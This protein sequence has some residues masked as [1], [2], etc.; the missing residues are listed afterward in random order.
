VALSD[1]ELFAQQLRLAADDDGDADDL[2]SLGIPANC[3]EG[4]APAEFG[5]GGAELLAQQLRLAAEDCDADDELVSGAE[6]LPKAPREKR[7]ASIGA[8]VLQTEGHDVPADAWKRFTPAFVDQQRCQSRTFAG[9]YGGQCSMRPVAGS[10]LCANHDR[11]AS[12]TVGLSHGYETGEIPRRKL[13][14]F[15]RRAARREEKE[16]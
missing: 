13:L 5:L 16:V 15:V 2:L 7:R 14:E 11:E 6:G 9:G 12:R 3:F 1:A 4:G 10:D 8:K